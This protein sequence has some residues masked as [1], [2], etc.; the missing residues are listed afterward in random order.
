VIVIHHPAGLAVKVSFGC[1]AYSNHI[2]RV[3]EH[4][5]S[6]VGGSS[7]APLLAY[8]GSVIGLHHDS[9]VPESMTFGEL[10]K[11]L[12]AGQVFLNKAAPVSEFR[13]DLVRYLPINN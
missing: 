2:P 13:Q 11:A 9:G 4:D 6:T 5:C 12:E 10:R 1:L 8:D 7:G 3:L